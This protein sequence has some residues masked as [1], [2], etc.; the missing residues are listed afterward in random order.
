L[1]RSEYNVL[2][3]VH[4]EYGRAAIGISA[5]LLSQHIDSD[6]PLAFWQLSCPPSCL[7]L[8]VTLRVLFGKATWL[9]VEW[10][11][12][13]ARALFTEALFTEALSRC[14][15]SMSAMIDDEASFEGI[16]NG[17]QQFEEVEQAGH[18]DLEQQGADDLRSDA[19]RSVVSEAVMPMVDL[20]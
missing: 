12:L 9:G 1:A 6:S 16:F 15:K 13:Y 3:K 20:L 2:V 17:L 8:T 11:W 10:L 5:K 14:A 18:A 4:P 7:L 19:E